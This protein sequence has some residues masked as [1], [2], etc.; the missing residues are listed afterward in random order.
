MHYWTMNYHI[1]SVS[2]PGF[3]ELHTKVLFLVGQLLQS[4]ACLLRIQTSTKTRR[5]AM[6]CIWYEDMDSFIQIFVL[7]EGQSGIA[8][9]KQN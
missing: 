9:D 4:S 5:K 1:F 6:R 2:F 3:S 7:T 8:D